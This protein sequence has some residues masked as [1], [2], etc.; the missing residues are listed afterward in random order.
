MIAQALTISNR[1]ASRMPA[2]R[3]AMN[4]YAASET[5]PQRRV[6]CIPGLMEPRTAERELEE[7]LP[8]SFRH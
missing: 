6:H 1:T 5:P 2:G 3:G 7:S 4:G 8:R